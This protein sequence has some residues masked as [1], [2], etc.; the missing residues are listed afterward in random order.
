MPSHQTLKRRENAFR[1][2]HM[3][4]GQMV[5]VIVPLQAQLSP[6]VLNDG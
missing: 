2:L 6:G 4:Q 1:V 3:T 5:S